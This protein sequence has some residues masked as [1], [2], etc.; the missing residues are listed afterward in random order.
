MSKI[1]IIVLLLVF[2][3]STQAFSEVEE[4]EM[5]ASVSPQT[6]VPEVSGFNLVVS[7]GLTSGGETLAKTTDGGSLK[8]GGLFL[9]SAGGIYS[10]EN[11]KFQLQGT[12]GYH[13]DELSA[14]NGTA[15]FSRTSIEIIPFY[16]LSNKFRVGFGYVRA[17]SVKYSD[18]FDSINFDD[19]NGYVLE[20]DWKLRGNSWWGVRYVDI[21]YLAS[22]INGF[23]LSGISGIKPVDG[24]Y[25]GMLFHLAF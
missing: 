20:M 15:D 3:Q 13:F 17:M 16:R 2:F 12:F 7:A 11:S 24:S 18:P 8:A 6:V 25:F 23:D 21:E 5:E 22:S 10:F 14:D 9:M 19:A 1:N 4:N